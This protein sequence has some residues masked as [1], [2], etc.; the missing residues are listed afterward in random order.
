MSKP[1]CAYFPRPLTFISIITSQSIESVVVCKV[2]FFCNVKIDFE[3]AHA[4]LTAIQRVATLL[5]PFTTAGTCGH[6]GEILTGCMLANW[7]Y[8]AHVLQGYEPY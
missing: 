8:S 6:I 3:T 2:L 5:Q 7:F 4:N 1:M